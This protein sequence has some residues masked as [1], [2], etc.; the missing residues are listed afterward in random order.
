VGR[1][2]RVLLGFGRRSRGELGG[3]A[4]VEGLHREVGC[5]AE[6]LQETLGLF[7]LLPALAPERE[8]QADEDEV[9]SFG[10]RKRN[11]AGDSVVR[12]RALD[13]AERARDRPRRVGLRPSA[14]GGGRVSLTTAPA[15]PG[16]P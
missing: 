16:H 6:Q 3:E 8:R 9:D 14:D 13:D 12:R 5:G 15:A 11:D 10:S 7:D 4:L 1:R 2:D